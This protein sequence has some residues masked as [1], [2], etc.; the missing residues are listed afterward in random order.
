MEIVTSIL[1]SL[2]EIIY[3]FPH[4]AELYISIY[5]NKYKLYNKNIYII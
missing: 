1:K 2:L 3:T 4:I 5:I